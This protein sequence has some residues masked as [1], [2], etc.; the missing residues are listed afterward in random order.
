M[1]E[2]LYHKNNQ[3]VL[4]QQEKEHQAMKELFKKTRLEDV[5]L[6]SSFTRTTSVD[7]EMLP[8]VQGLKLGGYGSNT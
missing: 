7:G 8:I 5:S 3:R 1:Q 6:R 4:E 2:Y